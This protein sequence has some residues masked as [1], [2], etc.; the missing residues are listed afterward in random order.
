MSPSVQS[1]RTN[2]NRFSSSGVEH[3]K[4]AA[5]M[6]GNLEIVS[7]VWPIRVG[8]KFFGRIMR[9]AAFLGPMQLIQSAK[10]WRAV[11]NV[12]RGPASTLLRAVLHNRYIRRDAVNQRRTSAPIEPVV[13]RDVD[14]SMSKFVYGT[15][16]FELFRPRQIAQINEAQISKIHHEAE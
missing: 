8:E 1:W 12:P 3:F 14:V 11:H 13:R 10:T 6:R 9:C 15:H 16:E 7:A 4:S 2:G 5:W